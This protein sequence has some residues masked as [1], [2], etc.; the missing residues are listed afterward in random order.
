[1]TFND[2]S[3]ARHYFNKN[4]GWLLHTGTFDCNNPKDHFTVTD[5]EETVKDLRGEDFIHHCEACSDWD[6]TKTCF[7]VSHLNEK[8]QK[9]VERSLEEIGLN[10]DLNATFSEVEE[11]ILS[12]AEAFAPFD[13]F[14]YYTISKAELKLAGLKSERE[15][16][17][18]ITSDMLEF[19]R[20]F[21]DTMG[22]IT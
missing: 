21:P 6:E 3:E 10:W 1:M 13:D 15:E 19:F 16:E 18:E 8:G 4:G 5:C 11:R 12:L 9:H 22:D 2:Y 14:T 20:V 7:S 17:I